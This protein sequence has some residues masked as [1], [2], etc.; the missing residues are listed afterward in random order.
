[1]E[2]NSIQQDLVPCEFF[3][4]GSGNAARICDKMLVVYK[5]MTHDRVKSK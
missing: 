1:M 3:S 5:K 4:V 2:K